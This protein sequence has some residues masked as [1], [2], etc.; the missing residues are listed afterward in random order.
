[1]RS[2]TPDVPRDLLAFQGEFTAALLA[3]EPCLPQQVSRAGDRDVARRFGIYRN[4]V[5]ASLSAALA[6][7]FPVVERL[8]GKEFF[9]AMALVFVARH[10]PRSPVLSTYG[11]DFPMFLDGFEPVAALP[12]LSDVA[13]IEWGRAVAYH[14]ADVRAVDISTLAAIPA[15]LLANARMIFHPAACV[16]ASDYPIVSIWRTNTHDDVTS[17]IGADMP[18]EVALVSRP[19]LDVL[20]T[21]LSRG[22]AQLIVILAAGGTLGEAAQVAADDHPD[23][24]LSDALALLFGAGAVIHVEG[25][26]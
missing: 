16:I 7:C 6:A 21:P 12:Y 10:P 23:S 3:T 22:A 14:A 9:R 5:N 26:P 24:N 8:V 15:E 4:N 13:R 11:A 25:T 19:A 20:V 18:G 1:M 17:R 2:E